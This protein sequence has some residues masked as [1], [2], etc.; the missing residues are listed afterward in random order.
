MIFSLDSVGIAVTVHLLGTV[1][2]VA[3]VCGI[4]LRSSGHIPRIETSRAE[5]SKWLML[6]VAMVMCADWALA[7]MR[8]SSNGECSGIR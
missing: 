5:G 3:S 6:R 2:V 1:E 7:A 8:A 4:K